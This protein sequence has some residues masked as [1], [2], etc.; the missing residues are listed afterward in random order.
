MK[1]HHITPFILH[2]CNPTHPN[3]KSKKAIIWTP[4]KKYQWKTQFRFTSLFGIGCL[5]GIFIVNIISGHFFLKKKDYSSFWTHVGSKKTTVLS[6]PGPFLGP[7]GRLRRLRLR[8]LRWWGR[9]RGWAGCGDYDGRGLL[10]PRP[11]DPVEDGGWG[12]FQV[13][14]QPVWMVSGG[15]HKGKICSWLNISV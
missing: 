15:W 14:K 10:R 5:S 12:K 1:K 8:R 13:P 4:N 6:R 7:V 9:S 3:T 2:L 11:W